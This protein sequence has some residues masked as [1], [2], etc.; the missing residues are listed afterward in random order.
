MIPLCQII[1]LY[2]FVILLPLRFFT[3]PSFLFLP[4]FSG[5]AVRME[6]K[7]I[8]GVGGKMRLSNVKI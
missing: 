6:M 7:Q 8:E 5:A 1:L 2:F 3:A 4:D